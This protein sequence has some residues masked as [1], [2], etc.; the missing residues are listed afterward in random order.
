MVVHVATYPG[1]TLGCFAVIVRTGALSVPGGE[2]FDI[3]Y[4]NAETG[5]RSC[6]RAIVEPQPNRIISHH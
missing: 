1:E 5:L 3:E 4:V 6:S 2:I